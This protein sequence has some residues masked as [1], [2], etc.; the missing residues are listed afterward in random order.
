MHPPRP[1][2]AG[3]RGRK[4]GAGGSC[5]MQMTV[6]EGLFG[7]SFSGNPGALLPVPLSHRLPIVPA[8]WTAG[9]SG[10]RRRAAPPNPTRLPPH[11]RQPRRP[12][13]PLQGN[14]PMAPP[15]GPGGACTAPLPPFHPARPQTCP[16]PRASL[17]LL[18]WKP[19]S[20]TP[21]QS[22]GE[23]PST[24]VSPGP[25]KCPPVSKSI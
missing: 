2:A 24:D 17:S 11:S 10:P 3:T 21:G 15:A 16:A 25:A 18:S 4:K 12:P 14:T 23:G 5:H 20:R 13:G 8:L 6:C 19:R 9:D 7:F 22:S 1:T